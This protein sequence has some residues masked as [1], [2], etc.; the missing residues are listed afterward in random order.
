MAAPRRI[1]NRGFTIRRIRIAFHNIATR[2]DQRR[3]VPVIVLEC[4]QPL[5][6]CAVGVGVSVA[7][8][9]IINIPR[10]PDVLP[11]GITRTVNSFLDNLPVLG[12]VIVE[13]LI[14]EFKL[15]GDTSTGVIV[16]YG[17]VSFIKF[18]GEVPSDVAKILIA[19]Q[20]L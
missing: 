18:L 13:G 9:Q 2:I 7:E 12:I 16:I 20:T 8:N 19:R 1:I 5:I 14:W 3:H 15:E 4:K 17:L 6:E 10:S 11:V